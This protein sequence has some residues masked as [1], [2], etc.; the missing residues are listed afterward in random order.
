MRKWRIASISMIVSSGIIGL[1]DATFLC[2]Y[3]F[4]RDHITVQS[5]FRTD[6]EIWIGSLISGGVAAVGVAAGLRLLL[7]RLGW[8]GETRSSPG[9]GPRP[10]TG[11]DL[12]GKPRVFADFHNADPQG[13]LRLNCA[14][15]I[16]DL[17]EQDVQLRDGLALDFYSEDLEVE[18]LVRFSP[19]EVGW[20]AAID[21]DAIRR[22]SA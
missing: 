18:G 7:Q 1:A 15:T 10:M 22:E 8:I 19:E 3:F 16:R 9:T 5:D 20:V 14:G 17:A 2:V 21:W 4:C 13:R 11:S 6:L 12:M